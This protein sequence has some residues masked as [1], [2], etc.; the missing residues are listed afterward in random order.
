[1]GM[2]QDRFNVHLSYVHG[3]DDGLEHV[4]IVLSLQWVVCKGIKFKKRDTKSVTVV[5]IQSLN[6]IPYFR[7][8]LF[9]SAVDQGSGQRVHDACL[10]LCRITTGKRQL[11]IDDRTVSFFK[12]VYRF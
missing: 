8:A 9:I 11:L 1:M 3:V 10:K 4:A 2:I 6:E 12:P 5:D 7:F